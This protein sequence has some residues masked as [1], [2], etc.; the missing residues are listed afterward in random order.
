MKN[1]LKQL[2]YIIAMGQFVLAV[3]AGC[4]PRNAYFVS[5]AVVDSNGKPVAG[6]VVSDGYS[7]VQTDAKGQYSFV[8]DSLARYIFISVPSGYEAATQEGFGTMP[9]FYKPAFPTEGDPLAEYQ[10]DFSLTPIG[11]DSRNFIIFGVGDPQSNNDQNIEKFRTQTITDIRRTLD[12]YARDTYAIGIALGDIVGIG[13]QESFFKQK[14]VMGEA[15]IPFLTLPGN[16]DKDSTDWTGDAYSTAFGPMWYSYNV[17]DVHIVSMDNIHEFTAKEKGAQIKTVGFSDDQSEWLRKDLS[18]VPKDKKILL[19]YH[20]P[21]RSHT[22]HVNHDEV[23]TLAAQYRNPAALCGHTHYYQFFNNNGYGVD[24]YILGAACGYF[25]RSDCEGDG[26]PNGYNVFEVSGTEFTNAYFKGTDHPRDFQMRLYRGDTTFGGKCAKYS[27]ELGK[28]W[29]VANV[30][31]G[32]MG[33]RWTIEVYE[34]GEL[35]GEM[36]KMHHNI[37]DYWAYG[38]H[39]GILS[40]SFNSAK[41]P[42]HHQ[43]KFNLKDPKAKVRVQATDPWG[44]V[45]SHDKFRSATDNCD[46]DG[47]FRNK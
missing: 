20:I 27:Y 35:S 24:E 34:D 40:Y 5:G 3:S 7:V 39:T 26:V 15:G 32:G 45:Y 42:N 23:F 22:D 38:Y 28:E 30:F 37:P 16:H 12:S 4:S 47:S 9:D 2:S 14:A 21:E 44:N 36:E 19:V 25:W 43:Y 46:I 8:R 18:F 17:G 13:N 29:I 10:A 1:I 41:A 31:F 11:I 33:G 6:V